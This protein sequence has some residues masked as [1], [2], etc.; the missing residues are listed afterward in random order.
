MRSSAIRATAWLFI[1]NN[2]LSKKSLSNFGP[3]FEACC[4]EVFYKYMIYN[5][6]RS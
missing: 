3:V 5:D 2:G 4:G 1:G 6:L